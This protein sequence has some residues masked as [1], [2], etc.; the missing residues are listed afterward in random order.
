MLWLGNSSV[1]E[2]AGGG[3]V[4][5]ICSCI[6]FLFLLGDKT[7]GRAECALEHPPTGFNFDLDVHPR[8]EH[9]TVVRALMDE[10]FY[11]N[12]LHYFYKVARGVFRRKQ[13]LP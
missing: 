8:T 6:R 5:V 7:N 10:N 1:D 13:G 4:C 9:V 2:M 11:R 12:T 3:S